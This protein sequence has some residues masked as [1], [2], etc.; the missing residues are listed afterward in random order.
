MTTPFKI[1]VTDSFLRR[2]R[3][4][5]RKH[6]EL[7]INFIEIVDALAQDPFQPHLKL[8]PLKGNLKGLFAISLTYSYRITL[9]LEIT[10]K[11]ITI[12]D[13]GSHDDVY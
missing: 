1:T 11:A 10:D 12:V 4:F 7:K 13:I 2:S 9:T 6:P 3:K 8:H 5:F